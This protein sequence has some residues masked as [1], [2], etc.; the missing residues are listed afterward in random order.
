MFLKRDKGQ[1]SRLV[2]QGMS[3]MRSDP[4]FRALLE[5]MK[6]RGVG[7]AATVE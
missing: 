5:A 3:Q 6:Q 2:A 4:G 1:V 7:A